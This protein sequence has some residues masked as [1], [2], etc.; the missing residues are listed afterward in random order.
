MDWI[1]TLQDLSLLIGTWV[2]IYGIDS[3]RSEHRG[4]RQIEIAEETL[5]LFYEAEDAIRHIRHPASF[6]NETESVERGERESEAS[7][8]ARKNASVVFKRYND[9]QELFNRLHAMRYRFMAQIPKGKTKPFDDLRR[10]VSEIIVSAR[11]LSRLRAREHFRTDQQWEQH[12]KSVEKH[13]AVF[14]EGL[15]EE[16]LINPR[17]DSIVDDIDRT[18]REVISGKGTLHGVLNRPL[19]KSKG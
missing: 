8:D 7:W 14:W 15:K 10:I 1:G 9:H 13:E 17:L 6:S 2:A 4:K 16:D 12:Q 5:A 11:M 19:F 18:C 3:W